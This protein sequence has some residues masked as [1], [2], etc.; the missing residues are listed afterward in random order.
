[1]IGHRPVQAILGNCFRLQYLT[2]DSNLQLEGGIPSE[3][4]QLDELKVLRFHNSSL[5]G[6]MPNEICTDLQELQGLTADCDKKSNEKVSCSCCTSCF[7]GG[8]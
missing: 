1:M 6:T 4:G 3:I 7:G 5:A 8:N 2:L